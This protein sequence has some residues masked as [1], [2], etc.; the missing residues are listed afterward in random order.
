MGLFRS[1]KES[2]AIGI[3][4][5]NLAAL[6]EKF[7]QFGV[8]LKSIKGYDLLEQELPNEKFEELFYQVLDYYLKQEPNEYDLEHIPFP[9]LK[10]FYDVIVL[11]A[12]SSLQY[13]TVRTIFLSVCRNF[14]ENKRTNFSSQVYSLFEDKNLYVEYE[15]EFSNLNFYNEINQRDLFNQIDFNDM[16]I[17]A[18]M[19]YVDE[20]QYLA[21]ILTFMKNISKL[22][23]GLEVSNELKEKFLRETR[24]NNGIYMIDQTE[25]KT[26]SNKLENMLMKEKELVKLREMNQEKTLELQKLIDQKINNLGQEKSQTQRDIIKLY[27]ELRDNFQEQVAKKFEEFDSYSNAQIDRIR[28]CDFEDNEKHTL[29][30]STLAE[31]RAEKQ[32]LESYAHTNQEQNHIESKHCKR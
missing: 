26:L 4:G 3:P 13:S 15:K 19:C 8:D 22:G 6:D 17:E 32:Q 2:P 1:S 25:I 27:A 5:K 24:I 12:V 29:T 9:K 10:E 16:L 28:L 18:R 14:L 30:Q 11:P 31:L 23:T 20:R 7:R 21:A